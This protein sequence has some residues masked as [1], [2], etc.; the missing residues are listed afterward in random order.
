MT[1]PSRRTV[2]PAV[3]KLVE[4]MEER[5]RVPGTD[6]R[7]G[8]DGLIGLVPGIGDFLGMVIGLAVLVEARRLR[9]PWVVLGRMAFNLWLDGVLGS[10]PVLGD[11]WDFWF[12]ANRRNLRLLQQHA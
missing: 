7:F 1:A 4:L 11:A 9:V 12:K 10:I 2:S 8:L 5:F 3:E 6:F